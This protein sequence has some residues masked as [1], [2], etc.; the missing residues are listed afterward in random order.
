MSSPAQPI[1]PSGNAVPPQPTAQQESQETNRWPSL[2]A[3]I[4]PSPEKKKEATECKPDSTPG[5]KIFLE[6]LVVAVGII[7]AWI[8]HGQLN[9]MHD[10]LG[11]M[12][13]MSRPWIGPYKRGVILEKKTDHLTEVDWY[14]KNGTNVVGT[15]FRNHLDLMV[16][17]VYEVG[18]MSGPE[19][20]NLPHDEICDKGQLSDTYGANI[21]LPN[22]EDYHLRVTPSTAVLARYDDIYSEKAGLYLVGCIDYSDSGQ[23]AWYRTNVREVL[24]PDNSFMITRFGN[25]AK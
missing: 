11:Q 17:P 18:D 23:K 2:F 25:E 21:V 15:Q 12:V 14:F 10:T 6:G 20:P 1:Q 3:K 16:G 19:Q 13:A 9:V 22:V 8:Y 4:K 24:M 7:V 5:W